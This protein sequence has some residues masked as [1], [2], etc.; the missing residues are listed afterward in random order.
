MLLKLKEIRKGSKITGIYKATSG[1]TKFQARSQLEK[2]K[3]AEEERRMVADRVREEEMQLQALENAVRVKFRENE[4]KIKFDR[5]QAK[6]R[7]KVRTI[8][9]KKSNDHSISWRK[10]QQ[11]KSDSKLLL[12]QR[13]TLVEYRILR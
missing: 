4:Q 13:H 11:L 7:K 12:I 5:L 6:E 3:I 10:H 8:I 2:E 1:I 9:N